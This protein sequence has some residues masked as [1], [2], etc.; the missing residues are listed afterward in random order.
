MK[1]KLRLA[2]GRI[3]KI[4][5]FARNFKEA[6]CESSSSAAARKYHN[7]ESNQ[8]QEKGQGNYQIRTNNK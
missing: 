1:I 4:E 5:E 7:P 6:G 8:T 3:P 2:R